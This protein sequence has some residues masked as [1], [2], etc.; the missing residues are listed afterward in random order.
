MSSRAIDLTGQTYGYLTVIERAANYVKPSGAA[1][2]QWKCKCKCGNEVIVRGDILRSGKKTSCGC[3][4]S[5]QRAKSCSQ[6]NLEASKKMD[7]AMIGRTFGDL[8]VIERLPNEKTYVIYKC[9]C[10]CGKEIKV[11]RADLN[12]GARTHCGCKKTEASHY[13]DI[14]GQRFG[15]LTASYPTHQN[16]RRAMM[17]MFKC[18]CGNMKEIEGNSVTRGNTLSCGCLK[19]SHGELIIEQ[20][21]KNNNIPYKKEVYGFNYNSENNSKARFDF[22]VNNQYYIEYDGEQ[23]YKSNNRWWNTEDFLTSQQERDQAKN[24]WCKEHNIPLIRIP[25]TRL[26]NICIEDLLLETSQFII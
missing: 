24:T 12:S 16:N 5:N 4:S 26:K 13:K 8:T 2:A 14:T 6:S 23:H 3:E 11:R 17:W 10:S 9:K 7:K 21:L 15:L 20:L 1:L 19:Q 18:D 25:Y 22:L